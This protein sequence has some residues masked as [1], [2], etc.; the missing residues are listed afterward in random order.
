MLE[1]RRDG[2][3]PRCENTSGSSPTPAADDRMR[4]TMRMYGAGPGRWS[5]RG[6]QLQNLKKNES[7][8]PLAAVDAVRAGDREAVRQY[9]NLLTVLADIARATVCAEP[10]NVLM[11]ATSAPS[12]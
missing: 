1:L 6:P 10:G 11:A 5:G 4:G 12:N 3:A 8:L 7:N 2:A 9:G